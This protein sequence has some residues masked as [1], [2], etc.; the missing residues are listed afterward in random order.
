MPCR[1]ALNNAHY[2]LTSNLYSLQIPDE[3][4]VTSFLQDK[5]V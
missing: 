3:Q 4:K 1:D 2:G 5:L